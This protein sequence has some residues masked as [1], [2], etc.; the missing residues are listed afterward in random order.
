MP[1]QSYARESAGRIVAAAQA[2][3]LPIWQSGAMRAFRLRPYSAPLLALA[4]A[5]SAGCGGGTETPASSSSAA[6]QNTRALGPDGASFTDPQ[7][8]YTMTVAARWTVQSGGFVK[9]VESWAIAPAGEGFAPN[10]NVL[11]QSAPGMDLT[12]YID[13]SAQNLGELKLIHKSTIEGT[14]GNELGLLEYS[15]VASGLDRPLHFLATVDVR[16]GQAIVATFT[17]P[18]VTFGRERPNIEP[19]LRTL[20][21]I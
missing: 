20:Q 1:W 10:V 2:C 19:Y 5:L 4:L 18:E 8:T 16:N 17:A 7:G 13:F 6:S 12:R 9:E 11:T 14:N 3:A 21:A 15:G